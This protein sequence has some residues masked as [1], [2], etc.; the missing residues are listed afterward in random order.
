MRYHYRKTIA[1]FDLE[2]LNVEV[3]AFCNRNEVPAG[4][5]FSIQLIIE[6]LITNIIKYGKRGNKDE[7]IEIEIINQAHEILL[8]ITDNSSVFNPLEVA[9]PDTGQP[10]EE[11]DIGGLGLYL[12]RKK[13]KSLYYENKNGFNF[14]K[15][16][17]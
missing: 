16:K 15:A 12:V 14:L 2:V 5:L 9:E 1:D 7:V 10:V 13:V 4:K 6:E 3:E 8:I 11:R 17:I